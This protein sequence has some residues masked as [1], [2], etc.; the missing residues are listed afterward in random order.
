MVKK[1]LLIVFIIFFSNTYMQARA[2]NDNQSI[3]NHMDVYNNLMDKDYNLTDF[4]SF[5][6]MNNIYKSLNEKQ[7][8]ALSLKYKNDI[9]RYAANRI[10]SLY[11]LYM[12]SFR[13]HGVNS[14]Y[15]FNTIDKY[16]IPDIIKMNYITVSAI[17]YYDN[18]LIKN[19][20]ELVS[21]MRR[22]VSFAPAAPENDKKYDVMFSSL[23][24]FH[25]S[26]TS[27]IHDLD[28]ELFYKYK[29]KQPVKVKGIFTL[30]NVNNTSSYKICDREY[31]I[32]RY[33]PK[34]EFT[35]YDKSFELKNLS[36]RPKKFTYNNNIYPNILSQ[37]KFGEVYFD[38]EITLGMD[39]MIYLH[40]DNNRVAL[41][42]VD[43]IK[44]N[45]IINSFEYRDF[46]PELNVILDRYRLISDNGS[47]NIR[48][49]P[50][51]KV[52]GQIEVGHYTSVDH[53]NGLKNFESNEEKYFFN[54]TENED[55]YN[56]FRD[57][58]SKIKKLLNIKE[59]KIGP[60]YIIPYNNGYG[61]I[62]SSHIK[63]I[64]Q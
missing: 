12:D 63:I 61:Y 23:M 36:I 13:S 52:I 6:N 24:E 14:I 46:V 54:N 28:N 31:Y 47:V 18:I 7:M 8:R 51:G 62:H 11:K 44:I 15:T 9:E 53:Y 26:K 30:S 20:P 10:K 35:S 56:K 39:S 59:F 38:A 25:A 45:K 22:Y 1:Y 33:L 41:I 29:G 57:Y 37:G 32:N 43:E 55:Y 27:D 48:N 60:W 19:Y 49:A 2:E 42:S 50:D 17:D 64:E 3:I 21:A 58:Y 5:G 4:G 16:F 34:T 40:S